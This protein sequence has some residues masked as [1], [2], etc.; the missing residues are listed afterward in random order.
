[1]DQL[2]RKKAA[3]HI[4]IIAGQRVDDVLEQ[5]SDRTRNQRYCSSEALGH[6]IGVTE[7]QLVRAVAAECD[8][9]QAARRPANEVGG[10]QR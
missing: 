3:I 4:G 5:P 10:Q 8:R 6:E 9:H 2:S 1:L 7:E